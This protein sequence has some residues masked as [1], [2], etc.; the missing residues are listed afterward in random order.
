MISRRKVRKIIDRAEAAYTESW[1]FLT[2]WK[3]RKLTLSSTSLLRYQPRL[4]EVIY[5]LGWMYQSIA[6][7]R[8]SLIARKNDLTLVSIP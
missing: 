1:Q 6:R 5:D 2:G 4:A 7:E 3:D 8:K